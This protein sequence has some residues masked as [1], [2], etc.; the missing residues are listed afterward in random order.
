MR[1]RKRVARQTLL[2]DKKIPDPFAGKTLQQRVKGQGQNRQLD[3]HTS[4]SAPR[5]PRISGDGAHGSGLA[6]GSRRC[7]G[8]PAGAVS[9]SRPKGK[10]C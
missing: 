5:R 3:R 4:P 8:D 1:E 2:V 9:P 10:E 7:A 6:T